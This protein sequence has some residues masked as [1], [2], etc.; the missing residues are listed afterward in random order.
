MSE[1]YTELSGDIYASTLT[2]LLYDNQLSREAVTQ[3]MNDLSD[4]RFTHSANA[5]NAPLQNGVWGQAYNSRA[6]FQSDGEAQGMSRSATG[7]ITGIDGQMS[8]H[9]QLGLFTG[10]MQSSLNS[11]LSS[12]KVDSYQIGAYG[13]YAWKNFNLTFG[14]NANLHDIDSK[15]TIRFKE[16][17]NDNRASYKA[18]SFHGFAELGY[19]IDTS[20]ALLEPFAGISYAYAK[21][22]SFTESAAVTAL[23]GSGANSDLLSNYLG[24]RLSN[25]Y[26]LSETNS[27][28]TKLALGWQHNSA[29]QPETTLRFSD[30]PGF[31]VEG[32]PLD[33]NMFYAQAGLDLNLAHNTSLGVHYRGQFANK[34]Q[35]HAIRVNLAVNF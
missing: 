4:S 23:S 34:A 5:L 21:T 8:D 11:G 24:I 33:K 35:D 32:L 30:G 25:N 14:G 31:M 29:D 1:A 9:W 6:R 28:N 15:R 27:L 17:S 12:A 22:N 26:A 2:S 7:F 18:N 16:V 13:G 19:N 20:L 3:R 10:Y